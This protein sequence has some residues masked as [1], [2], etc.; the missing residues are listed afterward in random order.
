M[1]RSRE[2]ELPEHPKLDI[3]LYLGN[4]QHTEVTP[5]K[6]DKE[7]A[8]T[9]PSVEEIKKVESDVRN[10]V[11]GQAFLGLTK[12]ELIASYNMLR[13]PAGAVA[14][15]IETLKGEDNARIIHK[16]L[17]TF[18][19]M[20]SPKFMKST[21]NLP[22]RLLILYPSPKLSSGS[23][24]YLCNSGVEEADREGKHIMQVIKEMLIADLI[25]PASRKVF[26]ILSDLRD[27]WLMLWLEKDS[28][29]IIPAAK[30][31]KLD[32]LLLDHNRAM[33]DDVAR[34]EDIYD[35]MTREEIR[36]HKVVIIA[37]VIKNIP[38]ISS[39]YA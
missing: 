22:N 35:V 25:T 6:K 33:V 15:L 2:S 21:V 7:V 19:K 5:S 4:I 23:R 38:F 34:M 11:A 28:P 37:E 3:N 36:H 1:F 31:V 32:T 39:M 24:E 18:H 10:R 16:P 20:Q 12:N 27:D 26:G 8:S 9:I 14:Y 29:I 17:P 13:G 30:L